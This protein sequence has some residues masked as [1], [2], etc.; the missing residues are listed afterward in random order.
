MT[1]RDLQKLI[2]QEQEDVAPVQEQ[3]L[4]DRLKDKPFWIEDKEE[5]KQIH[6]QTKGNCCFQHI[7]GMPRKNNVEMPLF[8]YEI[9]LFNLLDRHKFLLLL[10]A[11]GIGATEFFLR[12]I[13][14]RATT[15]NDFEN[16]QVCIITGPRLQLACDLIRRLKIMFETNG[17]FSQDKETVFTFENVNCRVEAFPS[18][19]LNSMRGLSNVKLILADESDFFP[20]REEVRTICERYSAKSSPHIIL[21]STANM[22]GGLME[23]MLNEE[24]S[25]YK[26]VRLDYRYGLNKIYSEEEIEIAKQSPSFAREYDCAFVGQ[27]GNCLSTKTIERAIELGNTYDPEVVNSSSIKIMALDPSPGSAMNGACVLQLQ[28]NLI[29]VLHA[30]EYVADFQVFLNQFIQLY[31]KYQPARALVDGSQVNFVKALKQ[32]VGEQSEYLPLIKKYKSQNPNNETWWYSLMK[33]VPIQFGPEGKQMLIHTKMLLEQEHVAIN[34]KHEKLI[35]SLKTAY[36]ENGALQKD[37][38]AY[39][40][41]FDS[42]RMALYYFQVGHKRE[43]ILR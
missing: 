26:K 16:S 43:Y 12:Y 7:I 38:T 32:Y 20:E 17:I 22:P 21:C 25:I 8:D 4:F 40:D 5:H 13:A 41:I 3:Q 9:E 14:W 28:N 36:E 29:E 34:K 33:I 2:V 42:F 37:K 6:K 18:H 31:R 15:N 1:F 23:T 27:I 10:K 30:E 11:T 39:H 35:I 24:P 19:H